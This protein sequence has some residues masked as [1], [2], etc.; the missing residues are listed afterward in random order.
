MAILESG[1]GWTR[2]AQN[3]NN[4]L[5]WKYFADAAGGERDFG[6]LEC[7]EKET[8][9]RSI[10]FRDRAEA[11]DL[12]AD[13]LASS[14]NYRA[15]TERYRRDRASGVNVVDGWTASP[16]PTTRSSRLGAPP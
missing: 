12:M 15:D 13:Q 16:T 1:Y 4:L 8:S 7:P 3:A 6:V 11:F 2:L 14:D 5:G 10:V 9:D